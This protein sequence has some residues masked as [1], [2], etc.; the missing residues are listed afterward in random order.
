MNELTDQSNGRSKT[1][2]FHISGNFCY[3]LIFLFK[4]DLISFAIL[5]LNSQK[6]LMRIKKSCPIFAY[7]VTQIKNG[8][9]VHHC[10]LGFFFF[11]IW[12]F[13]LP[14]NLNI[15]LLPTINLNIHTTT[16]VNLISKMEKSV[17]NNKPSSYVTTYFFL[18]FK[19]WS[20]ISKLHN[21]HWERKKKK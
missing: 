6:W 9:A 19:F 7:F 11:L 1:S 4:L 21:Y 14:F 18:S 16:K 17:E 13:S 12:N 5:P 10:F 15:Y 3:D 2:I 20:C 8:Y